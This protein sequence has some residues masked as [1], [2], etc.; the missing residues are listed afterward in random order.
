MGGGAWFN[1][2]TTCEGQRRLYVQ[3]QRSFYKNM[4]EWQ[5]VLR[6]ALVLLAAV[7]LTAVPA[8]TGDDD[9]SSTFNL[10]LLVT[11]DVNGE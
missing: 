10:Q 4:R 3:T 11:A 6:K 7:A 2:A 1:P 8:A 9:A 5:T